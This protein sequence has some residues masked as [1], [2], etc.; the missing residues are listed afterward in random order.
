MGR[1]GSME[2]EI[3]VIDEL[4]K[5]IQ[6]GWKVINLKGVSPDAIAV[7]DNKIV[8]IEV[9]GMKYRKGKGYHRNWTYK[10]KKE[11]YSMFDDVIIKTFVYK[12]K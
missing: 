9:L 7:K 6:D 10:N 1:R 8:A 4:N 11:L 3:G 5:L 2:H 12:R